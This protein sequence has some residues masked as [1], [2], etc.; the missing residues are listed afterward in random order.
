MVFHLNLNKT[1]QG[2]FTK[3][4]LDKGTVIFEMKG[5]VIS[6]SQMTSEK[7]NDYLQIGK[8]SF[9][10]KSGDVDDYIN[11][12]CNPNCGLHV[13]GNRAQLYSL[14]EIK[15]GSEITYDFS[16]TSTATYD[17]WK[18]NCQCGFINCRKIISGFQYLDIKTKELYR[19]LKVVPLYVGAA[20]GY[21]VQESHPD[22]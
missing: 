4:N 8:D 14:Y 11:H 17:E 18:M 6:R 5:D 10:S 21:N 1:E 2:I 13:V 15:A 19:S 9:L 16:T 12:S 22:K 7:Y 20:N 3:V